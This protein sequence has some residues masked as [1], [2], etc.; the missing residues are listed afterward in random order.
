MRMPIQPKP[1]ESKDEFI[2][3]CISKEVKTGKAQDVAIAICMTAWNDRN[4]K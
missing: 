4:K 2:S 3:R 1:N